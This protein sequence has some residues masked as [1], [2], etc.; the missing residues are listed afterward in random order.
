MTTWY[1]EP[2]RDSMGHVYTQVTVSN[3]SDPDL[4]LSAEAMVDTGATY[5]VVPRSV[6]DRLRLPITGKGRVR[7]ATGEVEI[8][9][10]RALLQIN[11]LAE[12]NPVFISDSVD[13][14]LIGVVTL[15]TLALTVDPTTGELNEAELFFY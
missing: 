14:I 2:K 1:A 11:G 15:E 13:K 12:I 4:T 7:T 3:P 6:A 9:R 8:D 5:T 10:G